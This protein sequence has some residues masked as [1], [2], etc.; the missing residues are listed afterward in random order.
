M[1]ELR[2]LDHGEN[3]MEVDARPAVGIRTDK[4]PGGLVDS[5]PRLTNPVELADN[6][7]QDST[8]HE[9]LGC[10]YR[11]YGEDAV[12]EWKTGARAQSSRAAC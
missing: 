6:S 5:A 3:Q 8:W 2:F 11:F 10:W 1:R 7:A 4:T 12:G 9:S